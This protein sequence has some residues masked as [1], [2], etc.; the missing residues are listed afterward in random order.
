MESDTKHGKSVNTPAYMTFCLPDDTK[1]DSFLEEI[2]K[3]YKSMNTQSSGPLSEMVT[4]STLSAQHF[5]MMGL[6]SQS[7]FP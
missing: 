4:L 6:F 2:C 5:Y 7:P 1:Y 3:F